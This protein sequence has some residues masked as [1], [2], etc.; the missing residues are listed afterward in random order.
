MSW[1]SGR[2]VATHSRD[3]LMSRIN[4]LYCCLL[5]L[6]GCTAPSG[7]SPTEIR[8]ASGVIRQSDRLLIV[9]DSVWGAY[10]SVPIN[11]QKGPLISLQGACRIPLPVTPM[12]PDFEGIDR[13]ADG[14]LV[15]LSE[16]LRSLIGEDGL[17]AQYDSLL[18][19]FAN[20]GLE[21]VAV[22]P[23]PGGVSRI[24]VIWEGGYPDYASVPWSLRSTA[25][26]QAMRPLVVVH[27]LDSGVRGVELKTRD[28]KLAVELEVPKPDGEEPEA[29]R[30]RAPDLVWTRWRNGSAE[31]W[32]FLLLITSQNSVPR[33]Q[34]LFHWLQRFD[35][36][37]KPVGEPLDLAQ[38]LP[39]D[40]QHANWEGLSWFDTGKS[41][42]LVHEGERQVD[43]R[44]F[45]L[46]LPE[47]WQYANQ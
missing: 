35:L 40:I 5:L 23:L 13:L 44:A 24:A 3:L 6:A 41:V 11:G 16:R 4:L 26:R 28:A 20:R 19:E 17:I 29:Q 14:K 22:R 2:R 21:G 25:G 46:N 8:E 7:G 33:P 27:D 1:D 32:G 31:D 30:F 36:K 39:A 12:V 38:F 18:G 9:D 34:Y 45:I 10:S 15:F 43:S 37:G 47:D 42:V